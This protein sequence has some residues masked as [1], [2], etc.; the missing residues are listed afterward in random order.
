M[1]TLTSLPN[2]LTLLRIMLIPVFIIVFYLPFS[3]AHVL[4]AS[5]FAVLSITDWLDGYLARKLK[6]LSPFGAF[7]DPVADKLLV[8]TSLLLLVGAKE[9]HYLTIPAIVIVGREIVIS[10]LREWM[11]EVGKRA[12]VTVGYVGKIKTFLQ[13]VALFLLLAFNS[14]DT[15]GGISGFILL[16]VAAILTIWSMIIYLAIAWPELTKKN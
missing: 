7:L 14:L 9:I 12:S 16:Y 5:I 2:I 10:A 1:S 11:A 4:A 8:S 6:M 3:F 13:M 15:W